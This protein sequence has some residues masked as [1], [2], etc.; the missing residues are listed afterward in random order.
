M[1]SP[2][3]HLLFIYGTLKRGGEN[4]H[5]LKGQDFLGRART[6]PGYRLYHLQGYPGLVAD[7]A[8]R[9]SVAGELWAVDE[10]CLRQLDQLEGL[11]EGLYRRA[12]VQLAPP[13]DAPSVET[14][15]YLRSVEG[16]PECNGEW[17]V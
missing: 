17:P 14:Y 1:S 10:G 9:G 15:F 6:A 5:Y 7:D 3:R 4:E 12:P 13:S 16:A 11:A 2:S 8:G